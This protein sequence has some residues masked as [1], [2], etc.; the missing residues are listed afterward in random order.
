MNIRR[1]ITP[2]V[3]GL[4]CAAIAGCAFN[5]PQAILETASALETRSYQ[6]RVLYGVE[7]DAALRAVIGTLQDLG[8]TL[9]SADATLGTVTATKLARYEIRMTVS[10]RAQG[11]RDLV[12]RA[13]GQY[14]EPLVGRAAMPIEDPSTYQDFFLA[15]E[16]S[17]FL[18]VVQA[19]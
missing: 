3:L 8:F 7:R 6:T 9:D 13:S 2:A 14:S 11:E 5:P 16:H 10:V 15:L 17:V 12:V 1:P 18:S 19:H 4:A